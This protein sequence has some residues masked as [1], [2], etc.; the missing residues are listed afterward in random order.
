MDTKE[1]IDKFE[2]NKA[3][4]L[5]DN[6]QKLVNLKSILKELI[7]ENPFL[8]KGEID[9]A[10]DLEKIYALYGSL[11][12]KINK[13]NNE[14]TTDIIRDENTSRNLYSEDNPYP[15]NIKNNKKRH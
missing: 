7:E 10:Q 14:G 8:T 13:Q 6:T 15:T 5:L 11:R 3:D 12:D 4:K 2:A 9:A 1:L